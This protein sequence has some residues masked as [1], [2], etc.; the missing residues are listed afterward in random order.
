T[1]TSYKLMFGFDVSKDH[2]IGIVDIPSLWNQGV[3]VN[4]FSQWDGNNNSLAERNISASFGAGTTP[5]TVDIES[6]ARVEAWIRPLPPPAYPF[7]IDAQLA[8]TGKP[9]Y[10][11]NCAVCHAVNGARIGQVESITD[12]GTDDN[13]LVS[14]T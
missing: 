3:R 8:A 13:R 6:L 14:F 4:Y 1:F 9:V 11:A 5:Q 7:A 10:D 2:S 12:I